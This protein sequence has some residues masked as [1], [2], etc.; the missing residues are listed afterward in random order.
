MLGKSIH[1]IIDDNHSTYNEI[2]P[3]YKK[4]ARDVERWKGRS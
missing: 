1:I 2:S 3:Y 4:N